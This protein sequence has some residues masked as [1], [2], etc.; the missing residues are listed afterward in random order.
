VTAAIWILTILLTAEF[1]FAPVNLWTGRTI[2]NH[3]RFTGPPPQF[4]T[5]VLAPLKLA[6]ARALAAG[7]ALPIVSIAGAAAALA[8]SCFYLARLALALLA[9]RTAA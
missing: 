7:L 9:V 8:I 3:A 6:T 1:V 4:A 2:G 5:H